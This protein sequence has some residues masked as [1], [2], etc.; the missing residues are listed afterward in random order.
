MQL[1]GPT[2]ATAEKV[3]PEQ[4][5]S[6]V[7]EGIQWLEQSMGP[8]LWCLLVG[9]LFDTSGAS[10]SSSLPLP[11][12]LGGVSCVTGISVTN[13]IIG[14]SWI[15]RGTDNIFFFSWLYTAQYI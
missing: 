9:Q 12:L 5:R 14:D 10:G 15:S 2:H 6:E 4:E 8:F 3:V 11:L 7:A 1:G 13:I